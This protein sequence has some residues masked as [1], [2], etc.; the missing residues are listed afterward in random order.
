MWIGNGSGAGFGRP[1]LHTHTPRLELLVF[2]TT[3]RHHTTRAA[4]NQPTQGS[5][6]S[7]GVLNELMVVIAAAVMAGA[8]QWNGWFGSAMDGLNRLPNVGYR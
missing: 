7:A 6:P 3:A 4:A 1:K 2:T 5:D 8:G